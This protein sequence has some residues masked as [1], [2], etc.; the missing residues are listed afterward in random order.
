[1]D[2]QEIRQ[3]MIFDASQTLE[4]L[5]KLEQCFTSLGRQLTDTATHI[6]QFNQRADEIVGSLRRMRRG[7]EHVFPDVQAG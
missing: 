3:Q 7:R 4:T 6:E 2:D 5:T 1:M